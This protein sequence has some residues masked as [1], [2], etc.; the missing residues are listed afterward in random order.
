MGS[1]Q[2][3]TGSKGRWGPRASPRTPMPYRDSYSW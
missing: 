3:R 1:I 2:C